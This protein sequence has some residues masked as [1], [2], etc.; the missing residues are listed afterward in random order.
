MVDTFFDSENLSYEESRYLILPIPYEKTTSFVKGTAKAPEEIIKNSFSLELYDSYSEKEYKDEDFFTLKSI[1]FPKKLGIED[2][3]NL[4]QKKVK[5]NFKEDKHLIF[6]GGE[7]TITLPII[8]AYKKLLKENFSLL[9][10]DAHYDLRDSYEGSKFSHA[11][12]MRRINEE[13]IKLTGVGIRAGSKEDYEFSQKKGIQIFKAGKFEEKLFRE[14]IKE[15][16]KNIYISVDFDYFDPSILPA[17]GTPE[18]S[19]ETIED[20]TKILKIIKEED[21]RVVGTDFVEFSPV[22]EMPQ[23]SYIAAAIIFEAIKILY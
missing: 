8:R 7:H 15:L 12:V 6:F 3:L 11:C 5:E 4:I 13:G 21:K 22:K 2:S 18:I 19:G 16:E 10:F 20:F 1:N 23:Y 9:Y 14:R 17:V